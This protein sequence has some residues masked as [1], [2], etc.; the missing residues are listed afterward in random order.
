MMQAWADQLDALRGS[1]CNINFGYEQ[2]DATTFALLSSAGRVGI[3][4]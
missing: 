2:V 4:P 1:Q 3:D